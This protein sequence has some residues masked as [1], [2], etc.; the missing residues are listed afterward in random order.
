MYIKIY[1]YVKWRV[2]IC[3]AT[4]CLENHHHPKTLNIKY[5]NIMSCAHAKFTSIDRLIKCFASMGAAVRV[6]HQ[7]LLL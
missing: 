2:I 6:D 4:I 3:V 7:D 1:V 5:S